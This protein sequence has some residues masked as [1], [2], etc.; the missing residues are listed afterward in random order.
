M[1]TRG[2]GQDQDGMRPY[3][4][5]NLK[6]EVINC[7]TDNPGMYC[8]SEQESRVLLLKLRKKSLIK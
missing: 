8:Q 5:R 2:G 6:Q 1:G 3:K 4:N 7:R